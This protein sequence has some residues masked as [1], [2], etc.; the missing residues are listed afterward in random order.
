MAFVAYTSRPFVSYV[1]LRI[2]PYARY[3]RDILLRYSKNL[4]KD[5]SVDITT[6]NFIGKPR[7]SLVKV[8][9]LFPVRKRF[10]LVNYAR[11]TSALNAKRPWWMGKAVGQFGITGVSSRIREAGVWENV[12]KSIEK[13]AGATSTKP[14]KVHKL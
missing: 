8:S 10:G 12:V 11:D 9:E 4:P 1:H 14:N 2:P 6:M 13:S 3:S 5:A 7:G